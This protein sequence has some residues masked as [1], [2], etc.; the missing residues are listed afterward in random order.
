MNRKFRNMEEL[1]DYLAELEARVEK[2]EG[3]SLSGNFLKRSFQIWGYYFVAHLIIGTITGAI[4]AVLYL[5]FAATILGTFLGGVKI[6]PPPTQEP[7]QQPTN[8]LC[9]GL[10]QEACMPTK[11]P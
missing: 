7:K 1:K 2:V 4:F 8:S 11:T 6:N 5:I 10:Y 9:G 3:K